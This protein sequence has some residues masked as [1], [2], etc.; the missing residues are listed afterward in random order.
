MQ[1]EK[2]CT[3]LV[4]LKKHILVSEILW[5]E[6]PPAELKSLLHPFNCEG[7]RK[8]RTWWGFDCVKVS[9]RKG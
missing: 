1:I 6:N 7:E 8:Q 2:K 9:F 4:N 5:K 3:W